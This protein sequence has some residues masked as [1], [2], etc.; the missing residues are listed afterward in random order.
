[1]EHGRIDPHTRHGPCF[2]SGRPTGS[3][4]TRHSSQE[5]TTMKKVIYGLLT[6]GM[7]AIGAHAAAGRSHPAHATGHA[8]ITPAHAGHAH[9]SHVASHALAHASHAH[10]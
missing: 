1:M 4:S 8:H 10:A 2:E 3:V 6:V 5:E 9:A 7:L